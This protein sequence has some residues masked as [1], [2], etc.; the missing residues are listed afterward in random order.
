MRVGVVGAT[1]YTG[2]E[3]LRLLLAHER[4]E[5][6]MVTSR[7]E[8]GTRLDAVWP[9]LRGLCD[10]SYEAPDMQALAAACELVFFATPHAVAMHM[11]QELL[12]A[13]CRIIDLSAD[14][15]LRDRASWEHWYGTEHAAPQLLDKA[16][17]ALPEV[18]RESLPGA[19][20]IA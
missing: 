3:L 12:D 5:L 7:A 1:G 16:I 10:L 20:L 14:F 6:C 17:Y 2:V 4:V 11:A 15:R 13:G 8:A 19:Q 9:S 18:A